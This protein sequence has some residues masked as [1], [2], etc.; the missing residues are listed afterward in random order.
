MS[1][2]LILANIRQMYDK[3][4]AL[5]LSLNRKRPALSMQDEISAMKKATQST[6][7]LKSKIIRFSW[8][9]YFQIYLRYIEVPEHSIPQMW[10]LPTKIMSS[11][12]T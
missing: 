12:D 10:M 9:R 5:T 7:T 6:Q 2:P 11:C 3:A 1:R 8:L 4:S